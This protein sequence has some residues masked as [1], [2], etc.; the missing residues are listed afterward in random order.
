MTNDEAIKWLRRRSV[1]A[2]FHEDRIVL[3]A[4]RSMFTIDVRNKRLKILV[5]DDFTVAM[6]DPGDSLSDVVQA[7][8]TSWQT[9]ASPVDALGDIHGMNVP[10]AKLKFIGEIDSLF[11]EIVG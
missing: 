4:P 8:R 11:G 6:S 10:P 5:G 3:V 1:V 9:V 2:I 7:A